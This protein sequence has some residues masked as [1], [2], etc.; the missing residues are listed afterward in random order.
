MVAERLCARSGDRL[1]DI[2]C[3]YGATAARFA[4]R[5]G[6]DVTGFTLSEEQARVARARPGALTFHVRDWL[7]NGMA[8]A[9]F[10]HGYA[11]ES[12]EHMADKPGLFHEAARTLKS[13]GRF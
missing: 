2:G 7:A 8:E 12:T 1:V 10:D 4:E 13:G 5:L 9:S 6:V 11:I 3:G